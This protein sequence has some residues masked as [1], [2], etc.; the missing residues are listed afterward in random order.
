MNTQNFKSAVIFKNC[1]Q[2][3]KNSLN[4][5]IVCPTEKIFLEVNIMTNTKITYS[6][7]GDYLFLRLRK[8]LGLLLGDQMIKRP[9]QPVVIRR[10]VLEKRL[11][12][13]R[14]LLQLR[15]NRLL[16]R[17]H[18]CNE[19]RKRLKRDTVFRRKTLPCPAPTAPARSSLR[20]NRALAL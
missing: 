12:K 16:H 18:R 14:V 15:Q 11:E 17:L 4:S 7:Q 3:T 9:D 5:L 1:T 13:L 8:Y 6:Q 20:A 19:R 2:N 10:V